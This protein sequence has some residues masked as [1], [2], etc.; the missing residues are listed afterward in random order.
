MA[1]QVLTVD[2]LAEE[3][4]VSKTKVRYRL[5]QGYL[6]EPALRGRCGKRYW[7]RQQISSD[8]LENLMADRPRGPKPKEGR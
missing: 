7:T 4:S 3:A 5:E 8:V 6:P 1:D 2:D